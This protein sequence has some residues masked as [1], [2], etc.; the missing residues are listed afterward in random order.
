MSFLVLRRASTSRP[1]V[2]WSQDDYDV[3]ADG[4]VVGRIMKA[5]AWAHRGCGRSP[6]VS[7]KIA[8]RR[9]ATSRR[10]RRQ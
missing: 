1:S 2:E 5:A 4:I 10:A 3:L 9:T 6:T 8:R 7:M